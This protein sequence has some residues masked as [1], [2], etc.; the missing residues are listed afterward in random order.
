MTGR[1]LLLVLHLLLIVSWLGIDVGVFY[2]S[3]VMRRPGLSTDARREVRRIMVTLD[4]APRISL[5]LMVPSG[6]GLAYVS[7][8]GFGPLDPGFAEPTLWVI[9]VV[10]V[11]W[12]LATAWA[13]RARQNDP[14]PSVVGT[15]DRLDWY[16]RALTALAFVVMGVAS[17]AGGEPFAANWLAWKSTLFGLIVAAGLWIRIAARRY[18]PA[19]TDL[20]T[21]GDTPERLAAVNR[22]IRGVYP[23]VLTVWA[24][25]GGMIALA[26]FRP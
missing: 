6:L 16:L 1:N 26:V 15:F 22:G 5:I 21:R 12:A 24:G 17:L 7:G 14:P 13:F 8:L 3:F 19:M 2:S 20:L 4:L 18:R 10:A 9:A 25:I 11:V 23:A